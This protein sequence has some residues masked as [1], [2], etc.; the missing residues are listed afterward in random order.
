M[1]FTSEEGKRPEVGM[2]Q[3]DRNAKFDYRAAEATAATAPRLGIEIETFQMVIIYTHLHP[4][5]PVNLVYTMMVWVFTVFLVQLVPY[6]V[7]YNNYACP[8]CNVSKMTCTS[9]SGESANNV[10]KTCQVSSDSFPSSAA[11]TFVEQSTC[12]DGDGCVKYNI[13]STC[14]LSAGFFQAFGFAEQP[15]CQ[16]GAC[17][18]Y[19]FSEC[20]SSIG[21][22]NFSIESCSCVSGFYREY[23]D[24]HSFSC[25]RC[26]V[27]HPNASTSGSCTDSAD[28]IVCNCNAGFDGDG[29][30][31]KAAF[32]S[33]LYTPVLVE[34]SNFS[35]ALGIASLPFSPQ[36]IS[37]AQSAQAFAAALRAAGVSYGAPC[38]V[39]VPFLAVPGLVLST[40]IGAVYPPGFA[41]ALATAA[42]SAADAP[43]GVSLVSA[44]TG[45]LAV[46][47]SSPVPPVRLDGL[48]LSTST[49]SGRRAAP[50]SSCANG[51]VWRYQPAGAGT[52]IACGCPANGLCGAAATTSCAVTPAA[53]A[54]WAVGAVPLSGCMSTSAPL[55]SND[56]SQRQLAL[57]L[58]LGLGLGLPLLLVGVAGFVY[59]GRA[60]TTKS[61][62]ALPPPLT[63]PAS[64]SL[65]GRIAGDLVQAT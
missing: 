34:G 24:S 45:F 31:C 22:S 4:L 60:C 64:S 52:A 39:S 30:M 35:A 49:V 44:V 26:K 14:S 9:Q 18:G 12:P 48:A 21:K 37:L 61:V 50:A 43:P 11:P 27:C 28:K 46:K 7:G 29:M 63:P 56:D 41:L 42:P 15:P 5:L 54:R 2:T 58:G 51:I 13:S 8:T 25:K 32:S 62:S 36:N 3:L 10:Y 33:S 1:T 17:S 57:G 55:A 16:T 38:N 40:V 65:D 20:G 59:Y 19:K 47:S 23:L 6:I 53:G